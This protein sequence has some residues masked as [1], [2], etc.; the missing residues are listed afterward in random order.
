MMNDLVFESHRGATEQ[1]VDSAAFVQR[2]ERELDDAG[3]LD[4]ATLA[5]LFGLCTAGGTLAPYLRH[6]LHRVLLKRTIA[7]ATAHCRYYAER[8]VYREWIDTPID[9]GPDLSCWP[10]LVREEVVNNLDDFL[11]DD[12]RMRS[13]CHT[14]GTTG[15]ALNV[16]KSYEEV[17]FLQAYYDQV[18]IPFLRLLHNRWPLIL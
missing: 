2:I 7:H 8:A 13:I 3:E 10:V 15:E 17:R 16:H 6:V 11:A 5:D 4:G 1:T 18:Y 9:R 12:V 14:S